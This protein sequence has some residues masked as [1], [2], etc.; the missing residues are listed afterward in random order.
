MSNN[1]VNYWAHIG[2]LLSG[3]LINLAFSRISPRKP[4]DDIPETAKTLPNT[5]LNRLDRLIE[6]L[7]TEQA[8]QTVSDDAERESKIT[9]TSIPIFSTYTTQ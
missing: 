9:R 7:H 5:Q 3:L 4:A 6:N 2:G 8:V 1:N